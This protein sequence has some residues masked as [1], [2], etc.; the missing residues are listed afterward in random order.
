[1]SSA[2]ASRRADLAGLPLAQVIAGTA[3]LGRQVRAHRKRQGLRIDDAAALHGVSVDMLSRLENGHGG[4]RT[5]K[6]LAVLD[7]LGLAL[8]VAPKDHPWLLRLPASLDPV[9]AGSATP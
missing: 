5:D 9:D 2:P 1:M 7:G 8:V 3:D 4:V 6:L